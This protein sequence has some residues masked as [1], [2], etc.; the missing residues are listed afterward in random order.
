VNAL[1]FAG[2]AVAVFCSFLSAGAPGVR[3]VGPGSSV[4]INSACPSCDPQRQEQ[5][6][7]PSGSYSAKGFVGDSAC[8]DCHR[9]QFDSFETTPHHL[10]SRLPTQRSVAGSFAARHNTMATFNPELSFQ[11]EMRDGQFFETAIRQKNGHITKQSARLDIVVGSATKGQTYLYWKQNALFELPL[12]YWSS[13]K[14]WVNSPGYVD[15]SADFDRPAT[16]RCLECHATFFRPLTPSV[17]ENRYAEDFV[18]GISCERCHGPGKQHIQE[19]TASKSTLRAEA[20]L[21]PSGLPRER[22]IDICAQCHAGI[23]RSLTPAFSFR[24]GDDLSAFLALPQPGAADRVDVHGNQ[25][26]LL[27]RSRC[28]QSTPRMTCT[29]CHDVHSRSL[30]AASYSARCLECHKP[31]Q[32]GEV[33]KLGTQSASDCIR[34]HMPVQESGQLTVDTDETR[35]P[36]KVRNHWI[37][38]YPKAANR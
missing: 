28:F 24:P 11:M 2:F 9:E 35:L 10:T 16:P 37:R 34:C 31:E 7:E 26:A 17:T 32:C 38:V 1:F 14:R 23:G 8:R 18:L 6:E 22:Q 3:S 29:T 20:K 30:P 13:L 12:S 19:T 36:A 25:V 27:E 4:A 15:G 5:S 33:A 21:P